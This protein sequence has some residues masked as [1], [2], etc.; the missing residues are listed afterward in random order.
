[1]YVLQEYIYISV[2]SYIFKVFEINANFIVPQVPGYLGSPYHHRT[3]YMGFHSYSILDSP[4]SQSIPSNAKG[5]SQQAASPKSSRKKLKS[6]WQTSDIWWRQASG[7]REHPVGRTHPLWWCVA[8]SPLIIL[9]FGGYDPE[10]RRH[11]H[12]WSDAA[13]SATNPHA[14]E[15]IGDK[16]RSDSGTRKDLG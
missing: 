2:S 11:N 6:A 9:C 10:Y 4:I 8:S 3:S 15:E 12:G 13:D 16:P 7:Q 5:P 1:M 14:T